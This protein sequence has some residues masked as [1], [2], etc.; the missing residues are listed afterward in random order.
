MIQDDLSPIEIELQRIANRLESVCGSSYQVCDKCGQKGR[1]FSNLMEGTFTCLKCHM[2]KEAERLDSD[3]EWIK[4]ER[5]FNM[6]QARNR[7]NE[8]N[9][10]DTKLTLFDMSQSE[11]EELARKI[12]ELNR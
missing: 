12:Y 4:K 1:G 6:R 10:R 9:I 11:K 3:P 8:R 2:K 7:Y 5:L